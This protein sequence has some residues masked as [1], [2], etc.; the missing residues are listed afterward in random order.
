MAVD[1]S[2]L[3]LCTSHV[4][5]VACLFQLLYLSSF[6]TLIV[7]AYLMSVFVLNCTLTYQKKIDVLTVFCIALDC[8]VLHLWNVLRAQCYCV[9]LSCQQGRQMVT[10]LLGLYA[11]LLLGDGST[12]SIVS[13]RDCVIR[14]LPHD[15]NHVVIVYAKDSLHSKHAVEKH[16][17]N[18]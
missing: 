8:W 15:A 1:L 3:L 7:R 14:E 12:V 6:A 13:C 18:S 17:C 11:F 4:I 10:S 9:F 5:W 16:L 2:C